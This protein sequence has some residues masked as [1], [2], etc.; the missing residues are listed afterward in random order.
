MI[1]LNYLLQNKKG[2]KY[3]LAFISGI[4]TSIPMLVPELFFIAWIS[5]IPLF[6]AIFFT[7]RSFFENIKM[8]FVYGIAYFVILYSWFYSLHPLDWL[9]IESTKSLLFVFFLWFGIS[10]VQAV[11][12]SFTGFFYRV[13]NP[14]NIYK[15]ITLPFVWII[16][17]WIIE[18]TIWGMPWGRLAVSQYKFL[19]AIQSS[20][21]FGSLFVS[22]IIVFTNSLLAYSLTVIDKKRIFRAVILSSALIFTVNTGFGVIRLALQTSNQNSVKVA[23][24]QGNLGSGEKWNEGGAN[25][26]DIFMDLSLQAAQDGAKIILWPETAVPI[27]IQKNNFYDLAYKNFAIN[28]DIYL[29]V[30]GFTEKD[31][32]NYSALVMY[33]PD[34][35]GGLENAYFK[36][37]LVPFGEYVPYREIITKIAPFLSD[38]RMLGDDLTASHDTVI[39]QSEYGNMSGLICFDSIFSYLSAGDVRQGSELLLVGTND[40]YYTN[41][42]NPYQHN[43][44]AVLRATENNRYVLRAANTG[45]SSI[46]SPYGH[47]QSQSVMNTQ[48]FITSDISFISQKTLYTITGDLIAILAI[49]YCLAMGIW[50]RVKKA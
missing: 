33:T 49:A 38:L 17:E 28:N 46:I 7:N 13:V 39:F 14:K 9:G 24:I 30:G 32:N 10:L 42:L 23:A 22:F 37:H 18:L 35:T 2:V 45:L 19:P 3:L 6:Y 12:F 47:I 26:F 21:L 27:Y 5:L 25:A 4:F 1:R 43:G 16:M 34:G 40:S 15:A 20:S 29:I 41:S 36:R 31:S 11:Q 8:F 48:A 50:F 44:Q